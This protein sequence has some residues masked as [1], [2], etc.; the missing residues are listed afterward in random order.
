MKLIRLI[1]AVLAVTVAA[2]ACTSTV[3]GPDQDQA[4]VKRS[5][6]QAGSGVG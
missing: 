6:G 3:T 1:A 5:M 2:A 4:P